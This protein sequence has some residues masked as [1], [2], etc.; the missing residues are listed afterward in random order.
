MRKLLQRGSSWYSELVGILYLKNGLYIALAFDVKGGE[1]GMEKYNKKNTCHSQGEILL[2]WG[3]CWF[4]VFGISV[5][6][7]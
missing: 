4:L 2:L 6:A 7:L 3:D 5:L 1:I